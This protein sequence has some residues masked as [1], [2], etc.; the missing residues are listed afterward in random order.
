MSRLC[1]R[2]TQNNILSHI[3]IF[4]SI[5]LI[6]QSVI[7]SLS[8]NWSRRQDVC[9]VSMCK[10]LLDC[11]HMNLQSNENLPIQWLLVLEQ[12]W[13][14]QKQVRSRHLKQTEMAY[15]TIHSLA[16]FTSTH[17]FTVYL[18]TTLYWETSLFF[19]VRIVCCQLQLIPGVY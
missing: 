18:P 10:M 8:I 13:Q 1:I 14:L 11:A 3:L 2:G 6:S 19:L 4:F 15:D 7:S 5:P 16:P 17:M 9:C 12:E